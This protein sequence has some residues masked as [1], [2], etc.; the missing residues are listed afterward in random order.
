MPECF[1][2][3]SP[4]RDASDEKADAF[5]VHFQCLDKRAKLISWLTTC[6]FAV[7]IGVWSGSRLL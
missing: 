6:S 7:I 4:D 1:H 5:F 3:G 2:F